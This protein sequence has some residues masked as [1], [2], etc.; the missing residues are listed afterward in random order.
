[1]N[2]SWTTQRCTGTARPCGSALLGDDCVA[3]GSGLGCIVIILSVVIIILRGVDLAA[4]RA[5]VAAVDGLTDAEAT[6]ILASLS[7][8]TE[9]NVRVDEP[10]D[11]HPHG[12][13]CNPSHDDAN[14][15][16][17]DGTE[18]SSSGDGNAT[19]GWSP[20]LLDAL[21]NDGDLNAVSIAQLKQMSRFCGLRGR[22]LTPG[23]CVNHLGFA[24]CTYGRVC[25]EIDFLNATSTE[26]LL[27]GT[28]VFPESAAHD[29]LP[30]TVPSLRFNERLVTESEFETIWQNADDIFSDTTG[31]SYATG[32]GYHPGHALERIMTFFTLQQSGVLYPDKTIDRFFFAT[33]GL[34]PWGRSLLE[35]LFGRA[36][37][38][39]TARTDFDQILKRRAR[40][41]K[42]D[43]PAR[44]SRAPVHICMER[45]VVVGPKSYPRK[46]GVMCDRAEAQL[47][48]RQVALR[49]PAYQP[50]LTQTALV[51]DRA[52][53]RR[54]SN[55]ANVVAQV[56]AL[57]SPL[58]FE[59]RYIPEMSH[60]SFAQQIAVMANASVVV[61]IHASHLS[62]LIFAPEGA[63]VIEIYP[64]KFV[65]PC[66]RML[67]RTCG[68]H[69]LSWLVT[70]PSESAIGASWTP[71][72]ACFTRETA[73]VASKLKCKNWMAAQDV[74]VNLELLDTYLNIAIDT[75]HTSNVTIIR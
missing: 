49:H 55:A 23:T 67:S 2:A 43:M 4:L 37:A 50:R 72:H 42:L 20:R 25:L 13:S 53:S 73:L 34:V 39:R 9:H 48:R 31:I 47:F 14:A 7:H 17:D 70:L 60:L 18:S 30:S 1:M 68:I 24:A 16:D 41:L 36:P 69:H 71:Q 32:D 26:P 11:T 29:D 74:H 12:S 22:L 51:I 61:S 57:L 46:L 56:D 38:I 5:K 28:L 62:N 64:F 3:A 52:S 44:P 58:G 63:V 21:V 54:M 75:L 6:V 15:A 40:H 45:A 33:T 35:T 8:A 27:P 59:T 10:S 19:A 65:D 66:F